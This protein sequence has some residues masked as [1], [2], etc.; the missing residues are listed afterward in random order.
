MPATRDVQTVSFVLFLP[1]SGTGYSFAYLNPDTGMLYVTNAPS[2]NDS[3]VLTYRVT[4]GQLF[5]DPA[6]VTV[7][8]SYLSEDE[9]HTGKQDVDP[10]DYAVFS[11]IIYNSSLLGG[12]VRPSPPPSVDLSRNFPVLGD[13]GMQGSCVGCAVA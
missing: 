4:D 10:R 12:D 13:Q 2:G 3:F 5:S 1:T 8:I 6:M 9:K 11:L 7:R